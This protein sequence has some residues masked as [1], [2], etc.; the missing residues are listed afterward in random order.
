MIKNGL[1]ESK[2]TGTLIGR[3]EMNTQIQEFARNSIKDGLSQCTEK[4][5]L[6]F[7]R[8]YSHEDLTVPIKDIVNKIPEDKLD[9]AMRQIE[10]TLKKNKA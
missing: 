4:Q 3:I 7:K 2:A 1:E 5:Q 8:M 10:N 9:W 6:F